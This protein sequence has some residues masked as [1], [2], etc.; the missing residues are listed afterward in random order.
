MTEADVRHVVRPYGDDTDDGKVQV[1][2]TLPIPSDAK[3]EAAARELAGKMGMRSP[4]VVHRKAIGRLFTFFI[5]YGTVDHAVDLD[6]IRIEERPFPLLDHTDVRR[7][8]RQALGREAVV[9]GA[10][11]G[12]DAHTVGL[13]AILSLKGIAGD[14]G[15]ESYAAFRVV[16]L[17]SQ[18]R[19]EDLVRRSLQE[20]ADA[21][22]I[23]QTVTQKDAHLHHLREFADEV[24]REGARGRF[25]MIAGGPRLTPDM[26]ADL[27]YDRVFGKGTTPTEVASY[28]AWAL[29]SAG[30][31]VHER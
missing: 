4:L 25:L 18:V 10:A 15:L 20:G 3:A 13:D 23:S 19:P 2:F 12:T 8:I 11:L 26:A 22:L 21:V 31:G 28:L 7:R 29:P 30:G 1:S 27:G 17:R 6:A 5:V 24:D 14:K 16:N 9:V